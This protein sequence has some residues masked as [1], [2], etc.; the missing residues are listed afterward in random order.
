MAGC[1]HLDISSIDE[2]RLAESREHRRPAGSSRP[3][4]RARC[5]R[6]R[7]R[8]PSVRSHD[9]RVR[10]TSAE[11]AEDTAT[12]LAETCQHHHRTFARSLKP[13]ERDLVMARFRD[14]E[15]DLLVATTVIEVGV[16]VP[17]KRWLSKTPSAW[18][19]RNCTNFEVAW[20]VGHN[21][22]TVCFCTKARY[23]T[24]L[25]RG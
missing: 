1:A 5:F 12:L 19:F 21:A 24:P 14:G 22:V 16:D 17:T 13:A 7:G 10:F 20:G 6:V 8:Q 9:R 11:A 3:T 4:H 2:L 18:G 25:R 23:H 15:V